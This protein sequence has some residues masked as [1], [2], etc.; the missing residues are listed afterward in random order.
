MAAGEMT[1]HGL[2]LDLSGW[3]QIGWSNELEPGDVLD[4]EFTAGSQRLSE[5]DA[6]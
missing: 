2:S 6:P 1:L 5:G 4:S 3:F